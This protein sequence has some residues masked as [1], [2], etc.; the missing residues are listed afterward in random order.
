MVQHM[1]PVRMAMQVP[2]QQVP[3]GDPSAMPILPGPPPSQFQTI[4]Y[5]PTQGLQAQFDQLAVTDPMLIQSS[6][7]V[8]M[9]GELRKPVPVE[10]VVVVGRSSPWDDSL[11]MATPPPV[12]PVAGHD[13]GAP[14]QVLAPV[15]VSAG[16]LNAASSASYWYASAS[17]GMGQMPPWMTQGMPNLIE[18]F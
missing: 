8:E 5:D 16:Q 1:V 14:V 9:A 18:R 10:P 7:F 4:G 2:I 6:R 11:G 12:G 13:A 15:Q 3:L 17:D